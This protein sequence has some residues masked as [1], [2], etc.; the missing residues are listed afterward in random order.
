MTPFDT[1]FDEYHF[2][3]E[4]KAIPQW[5]VSDKSKIPLFQPGFQMPLEKASVS[6]PATW[7]SYELALMLCESNQGLLPGFVLTAD[8]PYTVID[9]DVKEDTPQEHLEWFNHIVTGAGSYAER[10]WE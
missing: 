7:M 8:D 1:E 10:S 3:D 4:L 6:N 2:P 5:V 9:M